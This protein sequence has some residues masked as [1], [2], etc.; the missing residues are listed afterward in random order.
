MSISKLHIFSKNTDAAAS[1]RGYNYQTLKTLETWLNNL[2]NKVD[3]EIYCDFEEDIFQKNQITKT[4]KYRQIKL[5]SS[6]FSFKSEEIEKCIA[7]FFMLNIA[8]N[9]QEL[10]KE[11]VFEANS[12]VA[13]KYGDND[14]ELLREWVDN[15]N[16]LTDEQINRFVVKIKSIVS[17]YIEDQAGE[18]KEKSD[19]KIIKEAVD[20]FKNLTDEY[21]KDLTKRIKW[22]FANTEP[23]EEFLLTN[24]NIESL[25]LAL[26]FHVDKDNLQSVFGILYK[27]VSL[28]AS[29]QNPES[30]K[31]TQSELEKLLLNS[32]T[33]F[34]KLYSE[35]YEK[36]KDI[37]D[38]EV[39]SVGEFL[40]ILNAVRYCRR[41]KYLSNH[42]AKWFNLLDI[43]INKLSIRKEFRKR[44]IYEFVWLRLRPTGEYKLP[45]GDLFGCEELIRFYFS[46]F[47]E[48]KNADTLEDALN[49]L[50]VIMP[51][52][53]MEKVEIN[54]E[55]LESWFK[56][57][58]REINNQLRKAANPNEKCH[59][60]ENLGNYMITLHLHSKKPR[61]PK[62]ILL[63]F[64][65]ILPIIDEANFYDA[66]RLSNRI[67]KFIKI[68]VDIDPIRNM[69][70]INALELFSE[71]LDKV[72]HKRDGA[73]KGAKIQ[74]ER[75][76]NLI[77]TGNPIL[78]LKAL[79]YFHRA[80]D[81]WAQQETIE[82]LVLALINI[83][84]LYSALGLNFA[85][86]Y[87]ALAGIWIS[88]NNGDEK[89]LKRIADSLGLVFH[90]DFKQGSWMSS[91][92]DFQLLIKA[93]HE[94]NP[95]PLHE[96]K[97]DVILKSIADF[98][99][100]L[101]TI[102]RISP[103]F[104]VMVNSQIEGYND[105]SE[106]IKTIIESFERDY[107]TES[108]L[109]DFVEKR[110]DDYPLN[111][112]GAKRIIRFNALG[113]SWEISFSND[114]LMNAIAEEF[115]AI[116]QIMLAE[117]SLSEI[118][119]HLL[120]GT[121]KIELDLSDKFLPPE[122]LK[123]NN[124]Y[125]WR[126]F[127][128][129]FDNPNPNEITAHTA[130]NAAI[131]FSI[132][133][134]LSLLKEI[135]FKDM[136]EK[137]FVDNSLPSKTLSVNSYQRMYRMIFTKKQ[138]D[139]LQ[140]VHFL[141][142]TTDWDLP[143]ENSVMKWKSSISSKYNPEK[144]LENIQNRFKNSYKCIHITLEKL[145]NDKEF[146][147]IIKN[148]REEGYL[149]W[150]IILAMMNFMLSYKSQEIINRAMYK[151]ENE[152]VE[153]LQKSMSNLLKLDEKDC[154][155]EFP[156]KA[157]TSIE[158]RKQLSIIWVYILRVLGLEN[159]SRYPNFDVIKEFLDIRFNMKSD[160]TDL[161]NPLSGIA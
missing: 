118:D 150:Q 51:Q 2:L 94:L 137:F 100:A 128:A 121:I 58:F 111:D 89:L 112:S 69:E 91:I 32:G 161:D 63:Y 11:F 65:Q 136:F 10:D 99:I 141:E 71:K 21:W 39:F 90:A 106:H 151:T 46:D 62:V 115:C 15:Q 74:V 133:D 158:F 38:I 72:V 107:K 157:F 123:S 156:P 37:N 57:L 52:V 116:L 8:T 19:E 36:W 41:H 7:H 142:V 45:V 145:Q 122:Q 25:I 23:D 28:K 77:K 49:L 130:K 53:F 76:V 134:E 9:Y 138:F 117:I 73:Y 103:Q 27:E 17:K 92:L 26:P 83:S 93:R 67:N 16:K 35:V 132:L 5:Y 152:Y 12:S 68:L 48:F 43:F 82:G 18:L 131:L 120:K 1:I 104:Q 3:E 153:A 85:A 113:S 66:T 140:R 155:I 47:K 64:D 87:Y 105:I 95:K 31:L 159:K 98:S 33:E 143:S 40:E 61:N 102:S 101:F 55:E 4:A 108:S 13:R 59:L 146:H 148:L 22:K 44:A 84:Q 42:D 96:K 139:S 135:E 86:K 147:Q 81:L 56:E 54:V 126:I 127:V 34:D 60:L 125:K 50:N 78:L 129:N 124:E 110:L 97:D 24:S 154:Y 20:I 144:A 75:G 160:N 6:N 79:T 109:R 70:L 88:E 114:Y 80:K 29:E 14:A 149:D 30:R 119:F